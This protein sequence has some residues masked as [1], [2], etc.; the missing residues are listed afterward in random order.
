MY[1]GYSLL[2]APSFPSKIEAVRIFSETHR[3]R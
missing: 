3:I 2:R 1:K